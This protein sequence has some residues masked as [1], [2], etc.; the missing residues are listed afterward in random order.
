MQGC[1]TGHADNLKEYLEWLDKRCW[2]AAENMNK[3]GDWNVAFKPEDVYLLSTNQQSLRKAEAVDSL[4]AVVKFI[5]CN[6]RLF[7]DAYGH[8]NSLRKFT[9]E[10]LPAETKK[11]IAKHY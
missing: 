10:F 11:V 1:A 4:K 3:R 7:W 2:T 8:S 9:T 6:V 5:Q